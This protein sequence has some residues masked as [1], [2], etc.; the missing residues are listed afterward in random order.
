MVTVK[1]KFSSSFIFNKVF[2][3]YPLKL[4]ILYNYDKLIIKYCHRTTP[5]VV[6]INHEFTIQMEYMCGANHV[7]RFAQQQ[8]TY[9]LR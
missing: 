3:T 5:I 9:A 1:E 6:V 8:V 7:L 2:R 4:V